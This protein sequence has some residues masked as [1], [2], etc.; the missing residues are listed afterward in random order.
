MAAKGKPKTGGRL[1]GTPNKRTQAVDQILD[2]CE[3]RGFDPFEALIEMAQVEE[4]SAVRMT[5]IK[6]LC[7]YIMPKKQ[8]IAHSGEISNPYMEKSLPE[9]EKMIKEK[10]K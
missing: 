7:N 8:A 10:L 4:N 5:A 2:L 9:L 1:K 3:K 6:E